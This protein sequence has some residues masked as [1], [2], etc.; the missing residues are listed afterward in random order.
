M[1][2][3]IRY[4]MFSSLFHHFSKILEFAEELIDAIFHALDGQHQE[5]WWRPGGH[6]LVTCDN[7]AEASCSGS[8]WQF[9]KFH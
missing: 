1:L 2:N 5:I 7:E 9:R 8:H 6:T 4:F 3:T